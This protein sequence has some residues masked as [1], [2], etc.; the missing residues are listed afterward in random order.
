[1]GWNRK[2]ARYPKTS[3]AVI[4]T[5][6]AFNPPSKIPTNPKKDKR[7]RVMGIPRDELF[8]CVFAYVC[9]GALMLAQREWGTALLLF[10]IYFAMTFVYRTNR[11]LKLINIGGILLVVFFGLT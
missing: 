3:A 5:A 4:P 2:D 9:M 7:P 6:D 10:L 1:M 11:I 8:L